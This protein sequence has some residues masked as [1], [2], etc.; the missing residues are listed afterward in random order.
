MGEKLDAVIALFS[1]ASIAMIHFTQ[2]HTVFQNV[3]MESGH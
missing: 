3:V 2:N 1:L